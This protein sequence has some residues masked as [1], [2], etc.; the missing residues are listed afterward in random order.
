MQPTPQAPFPQ[1]LHPADSMDDKD[2]RENWWR[3]L[4]HRGFAVECAEDGP[5]RGGLAMQTIPTLILLSTLM[6]PKV[7]CVLMSAND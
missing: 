4:E 5:S 2:M 6:L 1:Q 7:G 3:A